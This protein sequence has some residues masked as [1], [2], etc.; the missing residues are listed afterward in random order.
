MGGGGMGRM[1]KTLYAEECIPPDYSE[2]LAAHYEPWEQFRE[3]VAANFARL[4]AE[5]EEAKAAG[6]L[7]G[8]YLYFS[9]GDGRAFYQIVKV[10]KRS[11]RVKLCYDVAP[12]NWELPLLGHAGSLTFQQ[13]LHEVRRRE[14]IEEL[15]GP[16]RTK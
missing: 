9:V 14:A 1:L 12:D 7:R 13:A 15:F 3:K 4:Q 6:T 2:G 16:K 5:D 10:N 8:R 11:V